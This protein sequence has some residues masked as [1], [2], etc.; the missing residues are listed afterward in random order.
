MSARADRAVLSISTDAPRLS[1][2]L[3]GSV[4]MRW[5]VIGL[6]V[7]VVALLLAAGGV[8]RHVW[9][10][11]RQLGRDAAAAEEQKVGNVQLDRALDEAMDEAPDSAQDEL[12]DQAEPKANSAEHPVG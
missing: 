2:I 12:L 8:A 4:M 6:L 1:G 7:S 11:K 10:H 5:L 3:R 9:R